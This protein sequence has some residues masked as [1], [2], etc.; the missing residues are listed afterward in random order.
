MVLA[1]GV[2]ER[3]RPLTTHVPKPLLPVANRPVMGYV[4]EHLARHGFTEV[5]ANLHYRAHDI[6]AHFG[7]GSRDG[8]SLSYSYEE[9]LC[10]SAGGL[11]R[12]EETFG[13]EDFLV[14]GADDLTDMNLTALLEAHRA[15]GAVAS[16]GLVEVEQTS[17]FGIVVTDEAGRIQQ[18]VE[19]PKGVAPSNTANTQIYLFS[20]RIFE[21]IPSACFHDFG[22]Q[23]FPALVAAGLPFYGFRLEGYW[24]D[25]GSIKDY[26]AAQWDVLEG[27]LRGKVAGPEATAGVRLGDGCHMGPGVQLRAPV[28]LGNGCHVGPETELGPKT[29]LG[30]RARVGAKARLTDCVVWEGLEVPEGA[31]LSRTVVIPGA[32]A[33]A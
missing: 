22:K 12:C 5:V 25:I 21:F 18:F 3:M 9:E 4:L 29:V 20:P 7:D 23:V 6:E 32:T 11:K 1:A 33:A 27:R 28:L 19:K 2:G 31:D 16:I 26:L 17:E 10:G 24:R 8:V 13:G 14:T 30:D 15:V